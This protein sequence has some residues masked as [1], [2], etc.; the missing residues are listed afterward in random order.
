MKLLNDYRMRLVLFGAIVSAFLGMT[1]T[2]LSVEYIWINKADMPT[3]R[4]NFATCVVSDKIYAIGGEKSEGDSWGILSSVEE[5]HSASDTW[6]RRANMPVEMADFD[7]S[8]VDGKI[9]AIGGDDGGVMVCM[10][11]PYTDTWTSKADMPTSRWFLATCVVDGKIYAIGGRNPDINVGLKTVEE[12]DPET[13]TWTKKADMLTGLHGLSANVVNGKIYAFGGRTN[14]QAVRYV[15]EYDPVTDI[16][17]PKADMLLGV[18]EMS[19]V[20]LDD[21]IVVI[22]GWHWSADFPYATVQ[23]YDPET[24]VWTIEGDAP[25]IRACSSTSVVNNRI[26]VIGGTD[27]PHPCPAT[28]TV[29][30]LTIGGPAPDFNGDG[31]VDIKDL[32]RLIESWDKDDSLLDV[33]PPFGDG[34]VDALDLEFLMDHWQQPVDDHTLLAHW[35]LDETEGII[36]YD[37]ASVNNAVLAGDTMWQ[38]YSGQING[39]LQLDGINSYVVADPVLNPADGPCSVFAWINGGAPGQVVLSQADGANWL[40]IDA[41]GNLMTE[42]T[43]PGRSAGPLFTETV[44]TDGQWHRIGLV[45]DGLN[46]ML[47]VDDVVVAED[48]QIGLLSSDG[49]LYIGCGKDMESGT[50]FSGLIDDI[51]IYNRVVRP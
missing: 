11:D 12:Y 26:Y 38:P 16:W 30:E 40:A 6:T 1:S 21:K 48:T 9:Y 2:C 35:A 45:W 39:A 7:A 32:L 15:Q 18:S 19:S 42:L 36:A 23:M 28:S 13:D 43:G 14:L 27:R 47:Y 51:R 17:I 22:G 46:R 31:M 37:S 3:P 50:Y 29:Y 10:Y 24:D 5:Y 34:V 4:W 20:V 49:G 8:V 25:F 44:I 33:A 41:E